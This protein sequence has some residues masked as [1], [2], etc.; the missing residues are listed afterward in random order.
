MHSRAQFEYPILSTTHM[1]IFFARGEKN[2]QF[3]A[4]SSQ[5]EKK[6]PL[7]VILGFIAVCKD[8]A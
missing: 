1:K 6:N 5:T 2:M 4:L 3:N 7:K 8:W